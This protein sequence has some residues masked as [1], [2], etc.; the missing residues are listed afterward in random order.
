MADIR[1]EKKE[2]SS[3]ILPWILGLL[4]AALAI[5][6]IAEAFEE[7]EEVLV[8]DDT[9]IVEDVSDRG[10]EIV[11]S[12]N[13]YT[14]IDFEDES[15]GRDWMNYAADYETYTTNM[16]GDMGLDHEFSH[17]A[18]MKLANTTAALATAHGLGNDVNV[19]AKKKMIMENANGITKDPYATNHADM[20]KAAAMSIS[21]ILGQVQKAKYPGLDGAV[22]EVRNAA[23]DITKE[24]L[25][26]NQ[27]EDVRDFFGKARVAVKAMHDHD[28]R[29]M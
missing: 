16:T 23:M 21:D 18:L 14:L 4:V 10:S 5:W 9:E 1:I 17:N 25:T 29:N 7:G 6:A 20:I 2:K 24:T 19:M 3:S 26:L 8:E 28:A 12:G 15:I 22:S 13:T 11:E 27:K